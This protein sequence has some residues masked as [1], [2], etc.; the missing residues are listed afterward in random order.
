MSHVNPERLGRYAIKGVIG[1]GSMGVVYLGHDPEIDRLVAIKT[2]QKHLLESS[3]ASATVT[4]R[5]RL[6][7]RAAGRLSHPGIVTVYD[8]GEEEDCAFI[9]MESPLVNS[10][11]V[12]GA[13]LPAL[14][15][16]PAAM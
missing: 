8:V 16:S 13:P 11:P 1:A 2:V 4:A 3:G 15:V 7:A 9:A 10:S 12:R 5:F 14:M 6:E